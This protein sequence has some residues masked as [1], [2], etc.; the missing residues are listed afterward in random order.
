LYALT[1]PIPVAKSHSLLAPYAGVS[2]TIDLAGNVAINLRDLRHSLLAST[3]RNMAL[4]RRFPLWRAFH[5]GQHVIHRKLVWSASAVVFASC[6]RAR[7]MNKSEKPRFVEPSR[8][9]GT[10]RPDG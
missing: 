6:F 1:D 9:A 8:I 3:T 2:G 7:V 5:L 10:R 4:A